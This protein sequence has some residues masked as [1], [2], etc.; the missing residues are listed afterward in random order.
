MITGDGV[1]PGK[2]YLFG[3]EEIECNVVGKPVIVARRKNTSNKIYCKLTGGGQDNLIYQISGSN[4]LEVMSTGDRRMKVKLKGNSDQH[5]GRSNSNRDHYA[6]LMR[7]IRFAKE[8]KN[9]LWV[10]GEGT[11]VKVN[12]ATFVQIYELADFFPQGY[13]PLFICCNT[14]GNIIYGYSVGSFNSVLSVNKQ[15]VA[16]R[17]VTNMM[18][19]FEINSADQWVGM[20][21]T[22]DD[23][24]LVYFSISKVVIK[25]QG[26]TTLAKMLKAEALGNFHNGMFE[27]KFGTTFENHSPVLESAHMVR[28]I[29]GYDLFVVA[30]FNSIA[31]FDM[32]KEERQFSLMKVFDKICEST[33][34]EL[35]MVNDMLFPL[36]RAPDKPEVLR[37]IDFNEDLRTVIQL[38]GGLND[39]S[40]SLDS[41]IPSEIRDSYLQ[42]DIRTFRIPNQELSGCSLIAT[43][44]VQQSQDGP[45]ELQ[46]VI[47][48]KG[49]ATLGKNSMGDIAVVGIN[50]K[51]FRSSFVA[52]LPDN[53]HICGVLQDASCEFIILD[54]RLQTVKRFARPKQLP[55]PGKICLTVETPLADCSQYIGPDE[56][57]I[58][59][60]CSQEHLYLLDSMRDYNLIEFK[61]FFVHKAKDPNSTIEEL[62][63][64]IKSDDQATVIVAAYGVNSEFEGNITM[65]TLFVAQ[66]NLN[67]LQ[68]KQIAS[69]SGL[70]L[71]GFKDKFSQLTGKSSNAVSHELSACATEQLPNSITYS[72]ADIRVIN[73]GRLGCQPDKKIP[74]LCLSCDKQIGFGVSFLQEAQ[75]RV[76]D[77]TIMTGRE[78][79]SPSDILG[80]LAGMSGNLPNAS[81]NSAQKSTDRVRAKQREGSEVFSLFAFFFSPPFAPLGSFTL[82]I[83]KSPRKL[84]GSPTHP[85]VILVGTDNSLLIL[86]FEKYTD[87]EAG[88]AVRFTLV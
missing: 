9:L 59:W 15:E 51:E 39:K 31:I 1:S 62:S 16:N 60:A 17:N 33:I 24:I 25:K 83:G 37:Y 36:P 74:M 38:K 6:N 3:V 84:L 66:G 56:I 48:S 73:Q 77:S 13:S 79:R 4:S 70:R 75:S 41:N 58:P 65:F 85:N 87:P 57:Y 40:Q 26:K 8:D 64:L 71:A 55:G 11:I 81:S 20:D 78:N 47:A 19:K 5:T 43:L 86:Y 22:F 50:L 34:I 68:F 2:L 69:E 30:C 12:E 80:V 35:V 52:V 88:Q 54:Y 61:N 27:R 76:S 21:V 29:K 23:D 7:N 63:I 14:E 18:R 49:I 32:S 72:E 45:P 67:S 82:P 10:K 42:P 53:G 28:R 46:I 44:V